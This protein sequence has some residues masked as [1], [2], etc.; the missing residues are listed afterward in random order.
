[1]TQAVRLRNFCFWLVCER[2]FAEEFGDLEWQEMPGIQFA[3][4]EGLCAFSLVSLRT[5][6]SFVDGWMWTLRTAVVLSVGLLDPSFSVYRDGYLS[7][8]VSVLWSVFV[9]FS[10]ERCWTRQCSL[11][12]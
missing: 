11:G 10:W 3:L 4:A 7:F 5:V 12:M 2:H 9:V 1:M 8:S 6:L